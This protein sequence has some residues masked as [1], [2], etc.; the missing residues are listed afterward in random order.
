MSD[1]QI[2]LDLARFLDSGAARRLAEPG[3]DARR[4]I[5]EALLRACREDL[6][7]AP[8][9]LDG[10]DVEALMT[11]A[12]PGRFARRDP[13]AAHVRPVI[14]AFFEHLESDAVVTQSFEIKNA[15]ARC[16]DRLQ[17]IVERGENEPRATR[18]ATPVVH[19]ADKLGRND[20]C[21][22][23]SGKKFKKCCGKGS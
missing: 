23:G 8:E 1:K 7:K 2:A 18:R 17:E 22:C 6:G 19:R 4:K 14:E 21:F 15:L 12:L 10:Q 20:P 5:A 11:T 9:E 16:G 3:S 13:L